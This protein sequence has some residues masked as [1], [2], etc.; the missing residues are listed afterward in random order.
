VKHVYPP[1]HPAWL[2]DKA[3]PVP[4]AGADSPPAAPA[5]GRDEPGDAGKAGSGGPADGDRQRAVDGA[6]DARRRP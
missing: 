1:R 2:D 3:G 6:A 5:G 4:G